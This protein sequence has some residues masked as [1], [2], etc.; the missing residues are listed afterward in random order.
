M[1]IVKYVL[2]T[3]GI[4]AA[5]VALSGGNAGGQTFAQPVDIAMHRL[6]AQSR[7]VEGTGFGSLTL[8]SAGR[9]EGA[10]FVR[11]SRAG[12]RVSVKCRVAVSAASPETSRAVVDCTQPNTG[13]KAAR[14]LGADALA[15]AVREHV[16]ATIEDR[17]Y[18]IGTVAN[19]MIA[20]VVLNRPAIAAT[21]ASPSERH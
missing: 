1:A 2:A 7:V 3:A 11:I 8:E 6:A 10:I 18:D 21:I 13:D 15:I 5:Y 14:R 12:D 19:R 9:E 4:G 17:A 20:F 16:A